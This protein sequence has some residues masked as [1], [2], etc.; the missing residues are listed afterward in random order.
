MNGLKPAG[1]RTKGRSRANLRSMENRFCVGNITPP[2]YRATLHRQPHFVI[3]L[4]KQARFLFVASNFAVA[5][6][7]KVEISSSLVGMIR[8][9]CFFIYLR[10]YRL[11]LAVFPLDSNLILIDETPTI[12]IKGKLSHR[13]D[14]RMIVT[15]NNVHQESAGEM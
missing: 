5:N 6:H 12:A 2:P 3:F 4:K 13:D 9:N 14:E 8:R 10:F 11:R 15:S 7:K 1:S